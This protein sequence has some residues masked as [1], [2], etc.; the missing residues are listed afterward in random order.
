MNETTKTVAGIFG[1]LFLIGGSLLGLDMYNES[2]TISK[3]RTILNDENYLDIDLFALT[4][5]STEGRIELI[6]RSF[7]DSIEFFRWQYQDNYIKTYF[8]R[9]LVSKSYWQLFEGSRA[10]WYKEELPM[11]LKTGDNE[12]T[13]IQ[14]FNY[15]YDSRHTNYVGLFIREIEVYPINNK[16]TIT[17]KPYNLSKKYG[18]VWILETDEGIPRDLVKENITNIVQF[19]DLSIDWSDAIDKVSWARQYKNGKV[20]VGYKREYY[21]QKIDPEVGLD[22]SLILREL[23]INKTTEIWEKV[24]LTIYQGLNVSCKTGCKTYPNGTEYETINPYIIETWGWVNK[25]SKETF[26]AI[27]CRDTK[28]WDADAY[29]RIANGYGVCSSTVDGWGKN[30][31]GRCPKDE[32]HDCYEIDSN[33]KIK[34]YFRKN[35]K[36][37]QDF[38][39]VPSNVGVME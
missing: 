26:G 6:G 1:I 15:Y 36:Y 3:I 34:E 33:C 39:P 35:S 27:Q 9:D 18:L 8:G 37:G 28:Y 24:N 19:N 10:I 20:K 25:T 7:M 30:W 12:A 29:C 38:N 5:L 17:F 2:L 11:K 16:E 31:R 4:N 22:P 23:Y 14:S 21:L 13:I 32:K